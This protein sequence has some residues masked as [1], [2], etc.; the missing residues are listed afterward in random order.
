MI[1]DIIRLLDGDMV[2]L[3]KE[4][5]DTTIDYIRIDDFSCK[6][7]LMVTEELYSNSDDNTPMD[8]YRKIMKEVI[9]EI[10]GSEKYC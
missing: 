5:D 1:P 10:E 7:L 9:D 6:M 4:Q 3:E 8:G 2:E